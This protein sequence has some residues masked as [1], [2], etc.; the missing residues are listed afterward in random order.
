MALI[1]SKAI[2]V[3][4]AK[5]K[6]SNIC[7]EFTEEISLQKIN[8]FLKKIKKKKFDLIIFDRVLYNCSLRLGG[9]KP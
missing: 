7:S 8:K 2:K 5:F 6:N 4:K 9:T 1:F 3:A